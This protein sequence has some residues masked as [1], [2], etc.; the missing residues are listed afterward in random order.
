[1]TNDNRFAPPS[2]EIADPV[3][4]PFLQEMPRQVKIAVGLLWLSVAL[5]IPMFLL[6]GSHEPSEEALDSTVVVFVLG[7]L[8][9]FS[10]YV[11]VMVYRGNNWARLV[12][13]FSFAL[14]A[15][16]L[17]LPSDESTAIERALE[18]LLFVLDAV[19]VYLLFRE[20]GSLWFKNRDAAQ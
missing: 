3:P 4:Q 6:S 9:I 11:N 19:T 17:Y 2:A 12:I 13:L 8:C 10:A 16:M 20:P 15:L 1:M 5:S 18:V 14:S 7:V